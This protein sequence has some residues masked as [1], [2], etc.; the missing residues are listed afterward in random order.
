MPVDNPRRGSV[1]LMLMC[2]C[3]LV[4]LMLALW[5]FPFSFVPLRQALTVWP[6]LTWLALSSNLGLPAYAFLGSKAWATTPD[7]SFFCVQ[8]LLLCTHAV[9]EGRRILYLDRACGSWGVASEW[10]PGVLDS[11]LGSVTCWLFFYRWGNGPQVEATSQVTLV[12]GS[13]V[14]L[15]CHFVPLSRWSLSGL[16]N[17]LHTMLQPSEWAWEGVECAI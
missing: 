12:I 15:W 16:C 2:L 11:V 6:W 5:V 3:C 8:L 17:G 13:R 1:L 14:T 7:L 10:D 4:I 9:L